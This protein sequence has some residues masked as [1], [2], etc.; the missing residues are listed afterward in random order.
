MTSLETLGDDEWEVGQTQ[1]EAKK[2]HPGNT[3]TCADAYS[4]LGSKSNKT[5]LN[6]QNARTKEN[7]M[8]H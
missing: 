2:Q 8:T 5:E 1:P 6:Y 4:I 3:E 7:Y